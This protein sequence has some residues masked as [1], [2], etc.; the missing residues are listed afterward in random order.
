MKNIGY[1]LLHWCQNIEAHNGMQHGY[2]VD[3]GQRKISVRVK[4]YFRR[5]R[6]IL[7]RCP[8]CKSNNV[9]VGKN[10]MR[11]KDE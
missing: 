8:I 11:I 5:K 4:D 9:R 7:K 10:V 6:I 3:L 1:K 2:Y